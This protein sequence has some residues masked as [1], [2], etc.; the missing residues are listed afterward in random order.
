MTAISLKVNGVPV[1]ADIEPRTQ[2]AEFLRQDLGLTGT[3]L[4]CEHGVCGACTVQ[5]DGRPTRSCIL[6]A[7][8]CNGSEVTTLEGFRDDETMALLRKAFAKHHGLQCG[9]CTPGMLVTARDI[10]RRLPGADEGRIREELAGNLCRCTGYM[11]IVAAIREVLAQSPAATAGEQPGATTPHPGP[12]ALGRF[13]AQDTGDVPER[14]GAAREDEQGWMSVTERFEV[15]HRPET[16]MA[17][18][19]DVARIAPC[20]PGASAESLEGNRIKGQLRVRF[21]PVSAT[22]A[23]EGTAES[24]PQAMEG[25]VTGSAQDGGGTQFQGEL[26]YQLAEAEGGGTTGVEARLRFRLAGPLAQF[27]RGGLAHDFVSQLA[28]AFAENV[29]RMLAGKGPSKSELGAV[30]VLWGALRRW[31]AR[32]LG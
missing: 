25:R 11:G 8:A 15:P 18:F 21:G 16:V 17:L 24:N 1:T 22:F 4:A 20:I 6:P 27:T 12:V 7:V 10:V 26:A 5:A 30:R 32:L 23:G 9:F 3:H 13:D 29:G 19:G 31:L 14:A 2:L 28:A